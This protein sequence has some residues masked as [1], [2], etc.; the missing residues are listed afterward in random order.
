MRLENNFYLT[1]QATI[2]Y[3]MENLIFLLTASLV[4]Y[5]SSKKPRKT[6]IG[7]TNCSVLFPADAEFDFTQTDDGDQMYYSE[8][9]NKQVSYGV[10]CAHLSEKLPVVEAQEVM[11]TYLGRLHKPFHALYNTGIQACQSWSQE[12]DC[13][14]MIDYWQDKNNMDWKV[15]GYTDGQTIAVLYVKNITNVSVEKQDEFLDS[16]CLSK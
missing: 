1:A 14:K 9:T 5:N 12:D 15:K 10:L 6:I 8:Y 16:F 13:I 4:I 2:F 11:T 3:T 7:N